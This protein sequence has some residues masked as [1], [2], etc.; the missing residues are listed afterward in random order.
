MQTI[1]K[2]I[3]L[4]EARTRT[5][6]L[7]PYYEFGMPVEDHASGDCLDIVS[8]KLTT[9]NGSNGNWGN[10]VANPCFLSEAGKTY[11]GMMHSYYSILNLIRGGIK[12][13]KVETKEGQIIF[14]EI[15]GSFKIDGECF[16]GGE[17]PA[18]LYEYAAYP[19]SEFYGT[20]VSDLTDTVYS[21]DMFVSH[22][23][24]VLVDDFDKLQGLSDYL[25]DTDYLVDLY[26]LKPEDIY[27]GGDEYLKWAR[28]CSV[29]D[30]CIGKLNIPDWIYNEHIKTPKIMPCA[31]VSDYIDWL[32]KYQS[33][34]G[35][36]CNRRLWDDMG[37]DDMLTFLMANSGICENNFRVLNGLRYSVP[38]LEVPILLTQNYTDVGVLSNVDGEDYSGSAMGKTRQTYPTTEEYEGNPTGYTNKPI[39]VESLLGTLR[40]Q[41][42]YLDDDNNVLPGQFQYFEEPGGKY[43]KCERG[44]DGWVV[45]EYGDGSDLV[46]ADGK[47]SE[48]LSDKGETKYYRTITIEAA[49]KRICEVYDSEMEFGSTPIDTFYFKAKYQN[50]ANV[51]MEIPYEIGNTTNVYFDSGRTLYRGDFIKD[52]DIRSIDG[53]RYIEIEYVIGGYFFGDTSG[54][55]LYYVGDGDIYYEKHVI[56]YKHVDYVKLDGVDKVPVY[57]KY[58][59]FK[60]DQ[61]RFYSPMYNL[62]RTGN[63]ANIIEMTTGDIWRSG[64]AYNAFLTKEEYLTNFSMPPKVDVDVTVDRGGAS[65]F[66]SHYRL[67]E[68]NTMQ[69]L[70]QNGNNFY[71]L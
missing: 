42:K 60:N 44:D 6:G 10:F 45:S 29:V 16:V 51:P 63:T 21:T 18:T 28:Y 15:V 40:D 66:E 38:Y 3:C 65:A 39:E 70:V 30:L 24:I 62:Y 22:D 20:V 36:C 68:C 69:D 9:A 11:N 25:Q 7:M 50:S 8:L 37:G 56:D 55:F 43:F 17:E 35:D 23:F 5:Q 59:D 71:N 53:T 32:V 49:A 58:I 19:S 2:T 26:E 13:R 48:E 41:K 46:N 14:T 12:L 1:K 67:T 34:S 4:E 54:N 31:D 47:T 27:Y 61:K 57:S 33:L 64:Y 52:I